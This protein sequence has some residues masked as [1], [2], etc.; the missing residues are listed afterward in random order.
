MRRLPIFFLLDVS[1]SMIGEHLDRMEEGLGRIVKELRT[2]PYALE[3]IHLS[4]IAF[5]GQVKLLAPLIELPSFY[6]PQLPVGG[7][8][9]LGKALNFLMDEI[10]QTV[11]RTMAE[12]K[13]DWKPII[14]LITDGKP[15]DNTAAAV[16]RWKGRYQP[17]A[18]LIAVSIGRN[19]DLSLLREL[20]ENVLILEESQKGDFRKLIGWVTDTIRS[21]SRSVAQSGQETMAL[22]KSDDAALSWLCLEQSA[23]KKAEDI[24][25]DRY[26]IF[27]G[28]CQKTKV[29]Y[30][31][32]YE[33]RTVDIPVGQS[34]I[35][36]ATYRLLGAYQLKPS[37]FDLSESGA[38]LQA[39]NV[40]QMDR[41]P[42][43][44]QCSNAYALISCPSCGGVY[45]LDQP[46][47]QRCP[48][49]NVVAN[50]QPAREGDEVDDIFRSRG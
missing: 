38:S 8:T 13:G 3:T 19:A 21:Q 11:I 30:L 22:A 17:H 29:P 26:A 37:Y 33:R 32:K 24:V 40:T 12:T 4:V 15:T 31:V 6:P 2:D 45:C 48:W 35:N 9:S 5:A 16:A 28:K 49:C 10:D 7:G 44:P 39:A 47:A 23:L 34:S 43:C 1:E 18:N 46:G 36:V 27:T 42:S 20:T 14:F 25:D 41:I 50:F